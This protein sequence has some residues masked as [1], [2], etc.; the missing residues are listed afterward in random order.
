MKNPRRGSFTTEGSGRAIEDRETSPPLRNST[1]ES[2]NTSGTTKPA[3]SKKP[4]RETGVDEK[5]MFVHDRRE[6]ASA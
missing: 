2:E 5:P 1:L 4:F 3:R 6:W